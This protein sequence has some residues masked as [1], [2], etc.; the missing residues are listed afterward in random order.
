MGTLSVNFATVDSGG[1]TAT[2]GLDYYPTNGTLTFNPGVASMSFFVPV[3][4]DADHEDSETI[5]VEIQGEAVIDGIAGV[6]IT[7]KDNDSC[8]YALGTNKVVLGASGGVSEP[9]SVAAA[10]GCNWTAVNTT[11]TAT[12]L[13]IFSGQSGEGSGS[14]VLSYDPNYGLSSRSAKIKIGD[15]V[16]AVTQ[17]PEPPP[18]E[19]APAVTIT[20]PRE[21]SRQSSDTILVSGT[22]KDNVG[23]TLVEA[24][25][26]NAAST[27]DYIPATGTTSWSVAL[28]GLIPGTNVIRVRAR[29]AVNPPTEVIR[30]IVY[31]E[32]SELTIVANGTG[33]VTPL[34]DGALLDVGVNYT[35]RATTDRS[36]EFTGWTGFIES[37]ANP[38]TFTM[39]PGFILQANFRVNPFIAVAGTYDG[40]CY[41][42]ETNRHDSAGFL[43]MKTTGV[44]A[45]TARLTLG[46]ARYAFSGRFAA[47]GIST[48]SLTRGGTNA[49]TVV[50]AIDLTER[51][52]QISGTVSA[53]FWTASVLC[54]RQLFNKKTNP[55]PFVGKY[56]VVIPGGDADPAFEPAG[57]S[58]GT[59]NVNGGGRVKLTATLADG[60]KFSQGATIAMNGYWPLY[61]PLYSGRGSVMSWVIFAESSEASFTGELNW[62]KPPNASSRYYPGGFAVRHEL[63]GSS[64]FVPTSSIEP[65]LSFSAGRVQFSAGNLNEDFFNDIALAGSTVKNLGT[66]RLNFS[67]NRS[68]GLFSGTVS[69]PDGSSR[70]PFQGA[71]HQ[72]QNLGWGFFLGTNQGGR[73]RF[74]Q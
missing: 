35:V 49:L 11:S 1:G 19:T 61:V 14:V 29:D 3:I 4:D 42:P 60:T 17:L 69:T 26:E 13:A 45:F 40:L 68:S 39:Q 9:I 70:I 27:G 12:W 67:I 15:K 50:L 23:V 22:A 33:K 34:R 44:G 46:G 38:L 71:L 62:V 64:Y 28:A 6:T 74:S 58:Y 56:T 36:H 66:N 5:I 65:V 20:S 51:S 72:K 2:P 41:D 32:T 37:Q 16:I 48:N 52:D 8:S 63:T 59:V 25:L 31:V 55:A 54:Q 21:N 73:V 43:T 30:T 53:G 57:F 10:D 47:D 18:D 7:L 24:R